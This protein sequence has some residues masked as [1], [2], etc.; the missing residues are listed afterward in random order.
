MCSVENKRSP[1]YPW[2]VSGGVDW[3]GR[4]EAL[5]DGRARKWED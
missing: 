3:W 4:W 1:H 2:G 5:E